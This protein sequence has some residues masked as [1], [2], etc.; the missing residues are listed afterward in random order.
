MGIAANC[1]GTTS[2]NA[3]ASVDEALPNGEAEEEAEPCS[4]NDERELGM[5]ESVVIGSSEFARACPMGGQEQC[6]CSSD[7]ATNGP[8]QSVLADCVDAN[9]DNMATVTPTRG[10]VLL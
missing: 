9:D 2:L 10:G 1:E 6:N 5:F 7:T 8:K 3:V 4:S